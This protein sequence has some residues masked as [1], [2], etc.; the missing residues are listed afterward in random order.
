MVLYFIIPRR[1]KNWLILPASILFY[2]WGAPVFIFWLFGWVIV[3]YLLVKNMAGSEGRPRRLLF[4]AS[5]FLN[6]GMLVYFKY[7]NFFVENFNVVL[8]WIGVQSVE[9]TKLVMPIGI[10]F[11]TFQKLSYTIEVKRKAKPPCDSIFDYAVYILM[12]PQ[13]LA[14]PIVR[15]PLM[16]DQLKAG[17][18]PDTPDDK[19]AG[20]IRF[21]IGLAKKVLIADIL[22]VEVDKIFAQAPFDMSSHI[23]W[24]G[25]LAYTFQIYFDFSGYSD[26]AIGIARM[27]GFRLPENFNSPYISGSIT[28]FWRR[29]HITLS[30]W[31]RDYLFLPLAYAVS[32]RMKKE[33]YL[34]IRADKIIYLIATT[35]T[36]LLCGFWHGAG[37]TFILWGLFQGAFLIFDR[38][39]L[40]KWYKKT[41]RLPSVI[42]TFLIVVIGWVIFRSPDLAFAK[43]YITKMFAFDFHFID[44]YLDREF[45][46]TTILAALFS[47]LA[48]VKPG[49]KLQEW[50]FTK[51]HQLSG[52][53]TLGLI[54]LILLIICIS[55]VVSSGFSPFIYFRF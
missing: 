52:Y 2:A 53:I 48:F 44:L 1:F 18:R 32:R 41:G 4:L 13:I 30:T 17:S 34:T 15:Y 39:F 16:A 5:L 11:I 55:Y 3:D 45:L 40:L 12:F 50:V 42:L 47:F 27:M 25:A 8:G 26:M 43:M 6:L 37:W 33:R 49:E 51:P 19:L 20:F 7:A 46:I 23:A 36:F 31:F 21:I 35:V 10:S 14:G 9:W 38:L 54:G 22:G 28:E 29:W 24:A